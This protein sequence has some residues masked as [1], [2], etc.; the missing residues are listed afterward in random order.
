[1]LFTQD[2]NSQPEYGFS[3]P[4]KIRLVAY[5]RTHYDLDIKDEEADLFLRSLATVYDALSRDP[6]L[7]APVP[8]PLERGGTDAA[9]GS[10]L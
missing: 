1:M 4:L 9:A 3:T 2:S 7:A 6:R 10:S 5:F 8:P